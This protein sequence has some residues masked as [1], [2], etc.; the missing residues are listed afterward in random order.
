MPVLRVTLPTLHADQVRAWRL[1][2]KRKAV[3]C[4]RR[5]GKS[6]LGETIAGD[7]AVKG[8]LVGWFAPTY[9]YLSE[10][11]N[12]L[13]EILQGVLQRSSKNEGVIRTLTKGQIDFWTM[14]DERCGRGRKYHKII[15]DEAAFNKPNARQIWEQSIEPTLLDYSGTAYV[16]SNTKGNSPENFFWQ[17]CNDPSLHFLEHHA[18]TMSNPLV[19]LRL[20]G[21][22]EITYQERRLTV[23]EKLKAD[24]HPLVY[25]QEYLAEFVD[26]SGEAFFALDKL[27]IDG[28]PAPK[29]RYCDTVFA[30]LDTAVK[31]GTAN[32][33]TAVTYCAVIRHVLPYELIILDWDIVQIEGAM[34][35]TWLPSVFKRLEELSAEYG[36]RRGSMGAF[37]EDAASGT[38][39]LQQSARHGWPARA[40]D[41]ELTAAG[42]DG[43][44]I[45]VSGYVYRGLVKFSEHAYNK[46]K[47]YKGVTRN[48]LVSQ[49]VEFRVGD[50]D[51]AK[52]ADDLLD[53][54]VYS[55]ALSLGNAEGY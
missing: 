22:D 11:Y 17:V 9:R 53:A 2:G 38:I 32:D 47:A 36:A 33:G 40:I 50:K 4:G 55:V 34:L 26:F 14:D 3:R 45:S 18:P 21:E 46:T 35:E 42:K 1:P 44:G 20:K 54:F 43:R 25:Q 10:P 23:F 7:G 37:I 41:S 12:D 16:L 15:I 6:L 29:P 31:T 52:R 51:A 19:P 28:K 24:N 5:W 49:V 30:V 27:L 48:H 8:E 39:L 13:V